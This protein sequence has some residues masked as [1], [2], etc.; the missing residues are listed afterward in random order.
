M[1]ISIAGVSQEETQ[2]FVTYDVISTKTRGLIKGEI[3]SFDEASGTIV[4]R[5]TQGRTFTFGREEYDYFKENQS[6]PV[7]KKKELVLRER[8]ND[9][10]AFEAGLGIAITTINQKFSNSEKVVYGGDMQYFDEPINLKVVGGKY[11]DSKNFAGV[12]VEYAMTS[13][14]ETS[15]G[16]GLRYKH[17]YDSQKKNIGLYIPVELL[18]TSITGDSRFSTTDTTFVPGG[19][20]WPSDVEVS[21]TFQ[22]I[23]LSIGPG[24]SAILADKKMI[25][26]EVAV[27]T[28]FGLNE[29]YDLEGL[30]PDS[31]FDAYGFKGTLLFG[32]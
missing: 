27:M 23:T 30:E 19:W 12:T 8:K 31:R 10:F 25:S 2:E 15:I 7:K 3:L 28:Q 20:V 9:E 26:F 13:T 21:S 6:F 4:F 18:Y 11:L 16:A 32:F 24:V 1:V 17:Y 14:S 22:A 5:D 29:E